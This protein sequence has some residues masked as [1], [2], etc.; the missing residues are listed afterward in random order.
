MMVVSI[1]TKSIPIAIV[2]TAGKTFFKLKSLVLFLRTFFF[3]FR[4]LFGKNNTVV[5]K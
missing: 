3:C 4:T 2:K 5:L 1:I